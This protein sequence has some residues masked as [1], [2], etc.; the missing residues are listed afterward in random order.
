MIGAG[1]GG[2]IFMAVKSI[3]KLK[4]FLV[5]SPVFMTYN[6]TYLEYLVLFSS[7]LTAKSKLF[8]QDLVL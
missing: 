8:N 4:F 1:I 7:L 3:L 5:F 6:Q 2:I